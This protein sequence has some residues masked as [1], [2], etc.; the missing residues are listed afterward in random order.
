MPHTLGLFPFF[1]FEGLVIAC[2]AFRRDREIKI[3]FSS[4]RSTD[5][6]W[7]YML[8]LKGHGLPYCSVKE[9]VFKLYFIII[10]QLHTVKEK[11]IGRKWLKK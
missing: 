2:L 9:T 3:I 4:I 5:A 8:D 11:M 7:C 1:S 10:Q 6:M